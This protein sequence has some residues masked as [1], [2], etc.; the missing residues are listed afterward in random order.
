MWR[1]SARVLCLFL[2]LLA[3]KPSMASPLDEPLQTLLKGTVTD[4]SGAAIPNAAIE[5]RDTN[6]RVVIQATTDANG[7]YRLNPLIAASYQ[8]TIVAT[9][10]RKVVIEGLKLSVDK[11]TLQDVMLQVGATSESIHVNAVPEIAGGQ[12]GKESRVG[13]FGDLPLQLT[14]FSVRSYTRTFLESRQALT[15]TDV[16]DIDAS[17]LSAASSS[18][19]S[20]NADT[21]LSRGFRSTD[22]AVNGLF[23]LNVNLPD[24]YFVERVDVFSGPSA[25]VMGAPR[26]IGGVVNLVP[27]RAEPRPYFLLEPSYLGK[28]VYGGRL[29]ASDRR[30]PQ[31][32]L[33]AR[34]NAFYREG[35]G[36]IRDSRLLNGGAA[37]GLDYRSKVVEFS[38]DAQ[39]LRNYDRAFQYVLLLSPALDHLPPAMPTNLST[40][41]AWVSASTSEEM[42]LGRADLNLSPK[43]VVT[44]GSGFSHSFV[45]YP[46][47][48]PAFLLDDSGTVLCEQF[49]QASVPENYSTD[50]IVHSIPPGE[51]RVGHNAHM[52]LPAK[53]LVAWSP[54]KKSWNLS[55]TTAPFPTTR[56]PE[57]LPPCGGCCTMTPVSRAILPPYP[58]KAIGSFAQSK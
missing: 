54:R 20:P 24:M 41:P 23:D 44:T 51:K 11:V 13:I 35:E 34:A 17:V 50:S 32:A 21:F 6:S 56:S 22:L 45:S 15:L 5:L 8:E 47:Y 49:N 31:G 36:E 30:G 10:F 29:D 55:G 46:G 9:G 12:L 26:S 39:Y 52:N 43:W 7:R 14:P 40:Q 16:F 2:H 33:G 53:T 27:K 58:R 42:I 25:F 48:C 28:S 37:L 1:G 57:V 18:K 4:T 19:S 38:F 3:L